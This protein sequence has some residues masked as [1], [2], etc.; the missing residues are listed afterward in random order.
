MAMPLVSKDEIVEYLRLGVR[1]MVPVMQVI[2]VYPS[3]D[4]IVSYGLYVHDVITVSRDIYQLAVQN[5]GSIYTATDEF[6]ILYVSFQND[7]QA[8]Q[9]ET[10][11]QALAQ[12]V[13]FFDG[14]NSVTF[15]RTEE[16]GN[17]SEKHTYTFDLQRTE[18]NNT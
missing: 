10:L 3:A 5:C 16:L 18:F 9:V 17:R 6:S 14:Y 8:E 2:D 11:I 1:D 4:D 7:P 15:S 12:N 13:M